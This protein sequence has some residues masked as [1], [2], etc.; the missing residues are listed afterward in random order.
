VPEFPVTDR[1]IEHYTVKQLS[2]FFNDN[3]AYYPPAIRRMI[4]NL[5]TGSKLRKVHLE[6]IDRAI[7]R[8]HTAKAN[9]MAGFGSEAEKPF[10]DSR[11]GASNEGGQY[12]QTMTD[13]KR[14]TLHAQIRGGGT[15]ELDAVVLKAGDRRLME[16]KMNLDFKTLDDVVH[17]MRQQA[18]FAQDWRFSEVRWQLGDYDSWLMARHARVELAKTHGDLAALI[19]INPPF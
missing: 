10:I 17:Q 14:L 11:R 19:E 18:R 12:G 2:D 16:I 13:H 15:L 4:N 5:P 6:E 8:A 9:E 3:L 7:R 1:A